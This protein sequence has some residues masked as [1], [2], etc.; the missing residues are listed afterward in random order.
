MTDEAISQWAI[1]I[2]LHLNLIETKKRR[3]GEKEREGG[4][5]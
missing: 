4:G 5:E 3:E 1:A 2:S